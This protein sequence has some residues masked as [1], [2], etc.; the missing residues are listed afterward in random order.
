MKEN[1]ISVEEVEFCLQELDESIESQKQ[2]DKA[3]GTFKSVLSCI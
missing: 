3:L 2:V 1:R